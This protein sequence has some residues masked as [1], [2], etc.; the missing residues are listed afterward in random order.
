MCITEI[1]GVRRGKKSRVTTTV[2]HEKTPRY[3]DLIKRLWD[4]PERP[5][6]WEGIDFSR[7]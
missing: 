1:D 4:L 3:P 2:S 5:G 7:V 6:Q